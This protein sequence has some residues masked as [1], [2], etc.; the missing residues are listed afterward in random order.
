MSRTLVL[1]FGGFGDVTATWAEEN[2]AIVLPEIQKLIDSGYMFF[3][4]EESG[5]GDQVTTIEQANAARSIVIPNETLEKLHEAGMMSVGG[6]ALG[7][8]KNTGELATTAEQV[9]ASD[10][11]VVPKA[12]GG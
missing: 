10:T 4:L 3:I 11:L 1:S 12:Q 7:E 2:D 5:Q 9:A 6:I 8:I